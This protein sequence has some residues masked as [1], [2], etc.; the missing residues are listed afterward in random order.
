MVEMDLP[1]MMTDGLEIVGLRTTMT[2]TAD[3]LEIIGLRT[4]M[5]MTADGLEIIRL[6]TTMTMTVNQLEDPGTRASRV[7]LQEI[8]RGVQ[9]KLLI[10]TRIGEIISM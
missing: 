7:E 6:R 8:G 10:V 2:M 1:T 5:T 9:Q 3:G 4:T